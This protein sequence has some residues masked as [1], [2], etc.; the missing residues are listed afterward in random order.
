MAA[1]SGFTCQIRKKEGKAFP[2]LQKTCKTEGGGDGTDK[3]FFPQIPEADE[4][5][6][7]IKNGG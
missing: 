7:G 1:S 4:I 2:Y 3:K 5:T 6:Q